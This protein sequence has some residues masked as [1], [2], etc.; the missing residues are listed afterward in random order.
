MK[1]GVRRA[2]L[3]V[4]TGLLLASC[5]NDKT[6]AVH[7]RGEGS[8]GPAATKGEASADEVAREAR[9]TLRCPPTLATPPRTAGA[10]VDDILG[11]RPGQT[12]AEAANLVLC[13]HELLVLN[14]GAGR[15]L[16]MQTYGQQIHTGFSA[17]IAKARVQKTPDQ[18]MR[19]M[20][21]AAIARGTNRVVRDMLLGQSKWYVGTVGVPGKERVINVAR[22]E[23]FE[24]G[25]LPTITSVQAAL[26][27]KYGVPTGTHPG[28]DYLSLS[29][30]YDP[31]GRP[32]DDL[33]C[34]GGTPDPDGATSYSQGCSLSVKASIFPPRDNPDLAEYFQVKVTDEKGG[35]ERILATERALQQLDAQRRAQEVQAAGK[36]ADA[37]EL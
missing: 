36:S 14:P 17:G 31:Q 12:Y 15:R 1:A 35:Y 25:K 30:N 33:P 37:P 5:G 4:T 7:E 27:R 21:D 26:I 22:E 19:E 18:I 29:W 11:V 23:W 10:P 13:S 3:T 9:G 34:A 28:A 16:D 6:G 24:A 8:A 20:S 32:R 2:I